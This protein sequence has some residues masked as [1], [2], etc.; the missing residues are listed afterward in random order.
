[1]SSI[2]LLMIWGTIAH[3]QLPEVFVQ[4]IVR[5]DKQ[6]HFSYQAKFKSKSLLK[7]NVKPVKFPETSAH[8]VCPKRFF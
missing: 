5:L 4:Q 2:A 7:E 3:A 8:L 6:G 1:M